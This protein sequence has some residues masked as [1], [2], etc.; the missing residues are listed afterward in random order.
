MNKLPRE[1]RDRL[2]LVIV[3]TIGMLFVVFFV[4]IH[5]QYDTIGQIRDQTESKRNQ[6]LVIE[7]DI[8]NLDAVTAQQSELAYSVAHA[9]DGMVSGDPYSWMFD[10][11]RNFKSRYKIDFAPPSQP[12]ISDV[13]LLPKFPYKQLKVSVTGT[14]YYHDLGKFI[15]DF[16]NTFPHIR[17]T[18][19]TV[20]TGG[21]TAE[22][23]EKLAFRMEV[24][25]L[26]KPMGTQN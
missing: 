5:P 9:E 6:L 19:L 26:V 16:E 8:K 2:I 7:K 4:L 18:N 22:G 25:A 12:V 11:L 21:A 1:K 24:V 13:D 10:T 20:D 3:G 23:G 17:I 15:A 14:A